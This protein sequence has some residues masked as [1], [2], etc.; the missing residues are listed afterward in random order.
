LDVS[1]PRVGG[2]PFG[3]DRRD[4]VESSYPVRIRQFGFY[5]IPIHCPVIP[6]DPFVILGFTLQIAADFLNQIRNQNLVLLNLFRGFYATILYTMSGGLVE[7]VVTKLVTLSI[8]GL[9]LFSQRE[10]EYPLPLDRAKGVVGLRII[11]GLKQEEEEGEGEDGVEGGEAGVEAGGVGGVE[12]EVDDDE[13]FEGVPVVA[14]T[15]A[16]KVSTVLESVLKPWLS[17]A[18]FLSRASSRDSRALSVWLCLESP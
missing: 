10:R 17:W 6:S 8:P 14:A 12:G 4:R 3:L 16:A 13:P 1:V 2:A 18:M 15:M 7:V 5:L 11:V 9:S